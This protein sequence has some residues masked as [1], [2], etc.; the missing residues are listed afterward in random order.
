LLRV[1]H[2][3]FSLDLSCFSDKFCARADVLKGEIGCVAIDLATENYIYICIKV[4]FA[5][6][7]ATKAQKGSGGVA[8]LFL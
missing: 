4:K 2:S 8:L 7:E 6:E 1:L 5:L 3:L